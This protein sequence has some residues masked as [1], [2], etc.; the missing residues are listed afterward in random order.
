MS[1]DLSPFMSTYGTNTKWLKSAN[2]CIFAKMIIAMSPCSNSSQ[3]S[4]TIKAIE[5]GFIELK[6][7]I[8]W[9]ILD[10]RIKANHL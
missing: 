10:I 8:E 1:G 6:N 2:E 4:I 9:P 3:L 7:L 5:E